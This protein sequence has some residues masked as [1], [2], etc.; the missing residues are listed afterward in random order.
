MT[1]AAV[2]CVSAP[3]SGPVS[4]LLTAHRAAAASAPSACATSETTSGIWS[5][6][7]Q[8]P[9]ALPEPSL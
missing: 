6:S 9:A 5:D 3:D 1:A 7:K 2:G 4:A 8:L